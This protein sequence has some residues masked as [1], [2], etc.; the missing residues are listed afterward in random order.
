MSTIEHDIESHADPL[1]ALVVGAREGDPEATEG[2][3]REFAT[4]A[5][6]LALRFYGN[7]TDAEDAA[8]EIVIRALRA[9]PTFQGRSKVM[10][11]L[12]TLAIRYL[13]RSKKG[14]SEAEAVGPDALAGWL[15]S[16]IRAASAEDEALDDIF[17]REIRE[18]CTHGMLLSLSRG[19]RA[20]YVLGELI[21]LT[22]VEAAE[23][24]GIN[25]AAYRQR[26]SRARRTMKDLMVGRCG[27]LSELNP[28]RCGIQAAAERSEGRLT[29]SDLTFVRLPTTR[30]ISTATV[31]RA[32][33]Q[34]DDIEAIADVY[35]LGPEYITPAQLWDCLVEASPD[36]L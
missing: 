10:T 28:C 34:L 25:P 31:T 27:L 20:A 16:N 11:W 5:F 26:L 32:M 29:E 14:R 30:P 21:G 23:A 33:R 12:Y 36:L 13:I 17:A 8:Q 7:P 1:A 22:D 35:R 3:A 4:Y 19:L 2:L 15:D 6:R 24:L 18:T 9:L